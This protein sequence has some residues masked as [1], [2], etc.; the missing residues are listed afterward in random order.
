MCLDLS[1][2]D[3]LLHD[4]DGTENG[5]EVP[6]HRPWFGR[7]W[8]VDVDSDH[9]VTGIR[10]YVVGHRIHRP[11]VDEHAPAELD[12]REETGQCHTGLDGRLQRPG[13]EDDGSALPEVG[14][15]HGQRYDELLEGRALLVLEQLGHDRRALDESAVLKVGV[16]H[17]HPL[18][19]LPVGDH[20]TE[21]V[22]L[23]NRQMGEFLLHLQWRQP[24]GIECTHHRTD[25]AAG[26]SVGDD[27]E[28]VQ[29]FEHRNMSD[30]LG[31]ARTESD[32]D[33]RLRI[34]FRV[35]FLWTRLRGGLG[36]EH[37]ACS[38]SSD[39]S[40]RREPMHE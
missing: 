4:L 16:D 27:P 39:C 11:S 30:A 7:A 33:L 29:C 26:Y 8:A 3:R 20:A 34:R 19:D 28:L 38:K 24:R 25:A 5:V 37:P 6:G 1:I 21:R 12:R 23:G 31:T 14:G 10:Q 18:P 36:L 9:E 22:T 2:H 35:A 32:P 17:P 13:V 15:D 40:R